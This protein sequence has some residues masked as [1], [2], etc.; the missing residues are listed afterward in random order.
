MKPIIRR[1]LNKSAQRTHTNLI[2]NAH[3]NEGSFKN[4][5][6]DALF[7]SS[8][9]L[10][11]FSEQ[12]SQVETIFKNERWYLIS[13]MRQ[14]L[15]E[16]YVEHGLIQ[17]L[18][19]VPV[20]DGL[21]GGVEIK[22]K[23]LSPEQ[24]E[25]LYACIDEN[26]DLE[27][28]G[29]AIKWNRLFGGAGIIVITGQDPMLP[30]NVKEIKE[31]SLLE[32]RAVDM[33]ELFW[34]KQGDDTT[35]IPQMHQNFDYYNYYAVKVHKSRVM[36][37]KG[38][39]APS[40]IRPR[41]RG[42]GYS[43]IEGV[44]RS[45]NQ[46]LKSNNLI[47]EVLD[48]FKVDYFKVK[49]LAQTL[50]SPA[51]TEVVQRRIA[52]ANRQK[53]YQNAV[54]MDSEDDFGS[55][56]LSFTGLSEVMLGIRTGVASDVR[57]PQTKL[58]G[59]SAAGFS[60]GEDDIENYNA[61]VESQVRSKCKYDIIKIVKLRSLQ[62]FGVIPDDLTVTFK[63]LRIL[64]T[65]QEET[66]KTQQF[67]RLHQAVQSGH[68]TPKEFKEGCNRANLFPIQVDPDAEVITM[69]GGELGDVA[70]S[71]Y[72]E[73]KE[74]NKNSADDKYNLINFK[75][76]R[77]VTVGLLSG[78]KI[79]TGKRRDNGLWTSPGGHMDEGETIESAAKR[80]VF[81]ETG[82]VIDT[83]KLKLISSEKIKSH[84]TGKDFALFAFVCQ[85]DGE[86]TTINNDPDK[87]IS[88]WKWVNL[89]PET[90][91]LRP[92][93]RHAKVDNVLMHLFNQKGEI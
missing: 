63:S 42:W 70:E 18:V 2:L 31:D 1:Q 37:M 80:E 58:F 26:G 8:D 19:D 84:R 86:I 88:E 71:D 59:Q 83:D 3:R 24:I 38:L 68:I 48:E 5:L 81:E 92:E 52:M 33:W 13:N 44:V 40:F 73:R 30:L 17:T 22:T 57:I 14:V 51:G 60:S 79:L 66:A 53:N 75:G 65:E 29:Q 4:G 39:Q 23:Q 7:G 91:E 78:D 93:V 35:L 49:G 55:K 82:I 36:A 87:E 64:S 46:Y 85:A 72:K 20:D 45:V 74:K 32:F 28:I 9:P 77:I 56:E 25:E 50:L 61:M 47:F 41:L 16:M 34:N 62:K 67:T 76:P 6:Q 43:V 10:S 54:T 89:S 12:L 27:T 90:P 69:M 15:S 21:R 11:R